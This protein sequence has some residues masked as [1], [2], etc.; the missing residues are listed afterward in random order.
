[1]Q[2]SISTPSG[3]ELL[4]ACPLDPSLSY[5]DHT[6]TYHKSTMSRPELQI[7]QCAEAPLSV[8]AGE[9]FLGWNG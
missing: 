5:A 2:M 6:Q 7:N 4:V 8:E 9:P 1:M 3:P